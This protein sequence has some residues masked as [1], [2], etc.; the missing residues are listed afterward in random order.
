MRS[1]LRILPLCLLLAL[2]AAAQSQRLDESLPPATQFY[3]YWHGQA[4]LEPVRS[5]NSL[6]RL[7][8]DTEFAAAR[9]SLLADMMRDKTSGVPS[10]LT[11][12][13]AFSLLENP[14]LVGSVTFPSMTPGSAASSAAAK[15][16]AAQPEGF[17][18]VYDATGKLALVQAA[19][20]GAASPTTQVKPLT[21]GAL[22]Y[23]SVTEKVNITEKGKTEEREKTYYRALS[24]NFYLQADRREVMEDLLRRFAAGAARPTAWLGQSLEFQKARRVMGERS[25]LDVFV[26]FR[27]MTQELN[28]QAG[29]QVSQ[30][31]TRGLRL[32]QLQTFAL[33][34][35]FDAQ[36]TRMQGAILGDTSPGG[37]F[38]LASAST[39]SFSTLPL[40]PGNAHSYGVNRFDFV[41]LYQVA[42]R[43][44]TSI[45]TDTSMID[46]IEQGME[47][48]LGMS[49]VDA[50]KLF[51]GEFG[52]F[53]TENSVD[54][55]TNY[56]AVTIRKQ[57][58]VVYLLRLLLGSNITN[59]STEGNA[60]FFSLTSSFADRKTGAPRKRFYYMAVTPTMLLV[61]PRKALLR[62]VIARAEA[63]PDAAAGAAAPGGILAADA[64]FQ[65]ARARLPQQ[66]SG[67]SYM[68][69]QRYPWEA[70]VR[71]LEE[72][73]A[74]AAKSAATSSSVP[75]KTTPAAAQSTDSRPAASAAPPKLDWRRLMNPAM[76]RRHLRAGASGW[77]KDAEGLHFDG[78]I[79]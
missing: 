64:K 25:A 39:A 75:P 42:R 11:R 61:A 14:L 51:T 78:Y 47:K 58:D 27:G 32:E 29:D 43:M 60:T 49:L 71:L 37:L 33:G 67:F 65:A 52:W 13:V 45:S 46:A 40:V 31:I 77:W 5:S 66:L 57:A 23:E 41:A 6:L 2:P 36:A 53:S 79:E 4:A 18:L 8:S 44:F 3:L 30:A 21:S 50:M 56:Y 10:F 24:G 73:T 55:E 12:D 54:F 69:F 62:E 74:A 28:A 68:D 1:A 76:L 9:E 59:E 17:F 35:T 16:K 19:L 7:W 26:R 34:V 20:Q 22:A 38:D 63:N 70:M 15:A 48:Q 72:E